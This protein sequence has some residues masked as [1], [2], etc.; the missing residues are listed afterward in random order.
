MYAAKLQLFVRKKS[1]THFN[2][3]EWFLNTINTDFKL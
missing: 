1:R 2:K 3:S